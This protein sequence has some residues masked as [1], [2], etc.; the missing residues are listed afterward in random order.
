[1]A[2]G[3]FA[4]VGYHLK[5]A[6][7]KVSRGLTGDHD[8]YA[9]LVDIAA[10]QRDE[11]ALREYTPLLEETAVSLDHSLYL[12][13]AHRAWGVAYFLEGEYAQAEARL[14]QALE[15]F[16]KLET[17]WQIGRTLYELANLAKVRAEPALA[18]DYYSRALVMFED[19]G[20]LP[21]IARTQDAL[22]GL[23]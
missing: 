19:I 20:A 12:A 1:M 4:L 9:M 6:L 8:L 7:H 15:L 11:A 17:R 16:Q 3:E 18:R 21:D 13:I 2:E 5:Q 22:E 14:D 23:D 10:Q